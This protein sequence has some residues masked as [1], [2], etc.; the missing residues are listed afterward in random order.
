MSSFYSSPISQLFDVHSSASSVDTLAAKEQDM[1]SLL[2]AILPHVFARLGTTGDL[3]RLPAAYRNAGGGLINS[4]A[5]AGIMR[6]ALRWPAFTMILILSMI[7][8]RVS[9]GR[10]HAQG[11]HST[12]P[13]PPS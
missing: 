7:V 3:A 9:S 6:L 11:R 5:A 10:R 4:I 12:P 8:A 2:R 13:H 1:N